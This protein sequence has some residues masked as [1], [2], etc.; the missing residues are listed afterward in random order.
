MSARRAC[1]IIVG[2]AVFV[3]SVIGQSYSKDQKKESASSIPHPGSVSQLSREQ[4]KEM[5]KEMAALVKSGDEASLAELAQYATG[6]D[7]QARRIAAAVLGQSRDKE[8]FD[9]LLTLAY[10]ESSEVRAMAALSIGTAKNERSYELLAE[11]LDKDESSEVKGKAVLAMGRLKAEKSTDKLIECLKSDLATVRINA[12]KGLAYSD[13]KKVIEP[14]IGALSDKEDAVRKAAAQSLSRLTG[15]EDLYEKAK[16]KSAEET[17][18]AWEEWWNA[19]KATFTIAKARKESRSPLSAKTW[20]EKYDTDKDGSL[21]EKELQTALDE[22]MKGR[23]REEI[24]KGTPLK[25]DVTVKK[26]DGSEAKLADLLKGTTLIY[27]FYGRCP[28]CVKAQEF[29]VKM[30]ADNKDKGIAFL[31]VSASRD[32]LEGLNNYLAKAKFGFPVVLDEKKEVA[33]QNRLH[34][35]PTVLLVDKDGKIMSSYRGLP[36]EKRTQLSQELAKLAAA[37]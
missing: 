28:H 2:C 16:S 7:P 3:L 33:T 6:S 24:K 23:T 30:C 10:D 31:G 20:I 15:Q 4:V 34:G 19:N 29:I 11:I 17:R 9:L 18:T 32:T 26:T 12:A 36:E 21:S 1:V 14:L 37:K 27:Y 13:D 22:M 5:A 8:A 35:T 25:A